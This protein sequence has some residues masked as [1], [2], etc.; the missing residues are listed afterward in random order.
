MTISSR[1][2]GRSTAGPI[3]SSALIVGAIGV[4]FGDIGTSPLY[5]F[6]EAFH[7]ADLEPTATNVLG[8][9]SLVFWSLV[10]VVAIKYISYVMR[11][12][13][14]G[15]GGILALTS[16]VNRVGGPV[17]LGH[18]GWLSILGLFGTALLY[19]DG[20]ITP[21]ISV[22]SA[23]EGIELVQ[24][25]ISSLVVPLACG[26]IIGLFAIQR[27]GTGAIGKIFGPIM[28]TWFL[29]IGVLGL[30]SVISSPSVLQAVSP[31]HAIDYFQAA[32]L[33]AFISLGSI[34]LVVTGGE[35]LYA[36]MG[37]FGRK[38]IMVGWFGLAMPAL[39]LNYF[40]QGAL[41]LETPG[42][43]NNPFYLLAPDLLQPVLIVIATMA[44]VI[45]S[46]ALISGAFSLT[47]QAMQLEF[48]PRMT[49]RHTSAFHKGQVYVPTVNWLLLFGSLTMVLAFQS[50]GAL[51]AAYGI[52]VTGTMAITT[53]LM[54]YYAR[55]HWGWSRLRVGT[56]NAVL[57][58][59]DL[60][61]LGG[62]ALKFFEGGWVPIAIAVVLIIVMTTWWAGRQV[63]A[64]R[65][66][67]Q[68]VE[69]ESFLA[70]VDEGLRNNSIVRTSGVAVFMTRLSGIAPPALLT[71]LQY[72]GVIHE[73][74][75]LVSI[76]TSDAPTV[77][78]D[79][80]L[81]V[82]E[83]GNGFHTVNLRYGYMDQPQ[84][85]QDFE[86]LMSPDFGFDPAEFRYFLGRESIV[87]GSIAELPRWRARLFAFQLRSAASAARFYSLPPEKVVEVGTQVL[88]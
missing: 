79:E 67:D 47:V 34:F 87:V 55:R 69:L 63:L 76:T 51:A 22:L 45:A 74:V 1:S 2:H 37:H 70:R 39:I 12:D 40:G 17:R 31:T 38:P 56:L 66:A 68:S 6:R 5:A 35:A 16:L 8:V 41:L 61:F 80:R 73:H 23:V 72:N 65:Y 64:A 26:I 15:E 77:P 81:V 75:L 4:V 59:V 71:N 13:D 33:A 21:A 36:D 57:L 28:I 43:I 27:R 54:G 53:I 85:A 44:T 3:G 30:I 83:L 58:V 11:A 78:L 46:Q 42:A 24:P 62:N 18:L 29:I 9:C 14:H 25:R 20:V 32:P 52:A 88:V 86:R 19:G 84:V 60:G 7:V 10:I 50:S 49:I 82:V 48:F